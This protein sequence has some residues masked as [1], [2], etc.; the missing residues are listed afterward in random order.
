MDNYTNK[1]DIICLADAPWKYP[2]WTNKQQVMSR[3]AGMGH[4]VLYVD[5]PLGIIGW[6]KWYRQKRRTLADLTGWVS[7]PQENV[8]LYSPV[9]FP[10]RYSWGRG[11]SER[12]RRRGVRRLAKRSGFHDVLVWAYHPDAVT[13]LK[14]LDYRFLLYDCVDQYR[15][16]P[17]YS[18]QGRREQIIDREAR[19]LKMADAVITTSKPLYDEKLSA[20]KNTFLVENVADFAHFNRAVDDNFQVSPLLKKIKRPRIGFVG[21]LDDYKVDFPIL[22]KIAELRP[23][24]SLVLVGPKAEGHTSEGMA[25]LAGHKN[26]KML[27]MRPR[28]ILPAIVKGFDAAIIPYKLNDYTN[29]CF[30]LKVYEFMALGIPTITSKL[31]ALAGLEGLIKIADTGEDFVDAIEGYLVWDP[32]EEKSRRI[33]EAGKHTWENRVKDILAIIDSLIGKS[34]EGKE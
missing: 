7:H 26:I 10:P 21:A 3:L 19:L 24:W 6:Y 20:N 27:G 15:A 30:P 1:Y 16:F 9:L 2:L 33:E 28:E 34:R 12:W 4:R 25:L 22:A 11:L 14:K 18:E 5:P 31:P 8:T 17:A 23:E 13:F 29:Y 32:K